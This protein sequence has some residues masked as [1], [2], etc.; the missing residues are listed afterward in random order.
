MQVK[1]FTI[2]INNIN[3]Y[4]EELNKFLRS[5]KIVEIE[6]HLVQNGGVKMR[7]QYSSAQLILLYKHVFPL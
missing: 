1:L 5:H 7:K 6:K 3:E 2:P 4:N